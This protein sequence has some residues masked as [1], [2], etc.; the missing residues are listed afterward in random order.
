M[1]L[2]FKEQMNNA[3]KAQNEILDD[4]ILKVIEFVKNNSM[5]PLFKNNTMD[6]ILETFF[7]G[8][9]VAQR[10]R[11][12]NKDLVFHDALLF[13]EYS[14]KNIIKLSRDFSLNQGK[15][16]LSHYLYIIGY[17][18]NERSENTIHN[19][20]SDFLETNLS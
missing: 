11:V 7:K 9:V 10:E 5:S 15:S 16:D 18:E 8:F 6:H 3:I 4:E 14:L 17:Y 1:S 2:K 12:L 19:M 13:H 20:I